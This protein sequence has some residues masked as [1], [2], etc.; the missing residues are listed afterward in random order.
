MGSQKRWESCQPVLLGSEMLSRAGRVYVCAADR[1]WKAHPGPR[2]TSWV[3][4]NTGPKCRGLSL[5]ILCCYKIYKEKKL[6][7]QHWGLEVWHQDVMVWQG[8]SC[9]TP[10]QKVRGSME[11]EGGGSGFP[12]PLMRNP[13]SGWLTHSCGNIMQNWWEQNSNNIVNYF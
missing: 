4:G 6:F 11:G 7:Y 3:T 2:T 10:R 9:A 13:L 12:P 8:L 5:S 1:S